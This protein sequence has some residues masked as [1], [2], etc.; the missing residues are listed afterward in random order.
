MV[1]EDAAY[2]E[3]VRCAFGEQYDILTAS[4]AEEALTSVWEHGEIAVIILSMTLPD[5]GAER[6]I[7]TLR[8]D[9]ALWRIPVLA[10]IPTGEAMEELPVIMETDDFLC[11]CHPMFDMRKRVDRLMD[12]VRSRKRERE[13]R[14]E[15]NRDFLTGLLNRRG[16]QM[17]VDSLSKADL[18][19][20]VYLFDLDNL[21]KTNDTCGHEI[22][23][24]VIQSF[25]SLLRR[26]TRMGD[27][28][29]RYGGDE[30]VAILQHLGDG[31]AALRK[32]Q[33]ICDAFRDSLGN[34]ALKTACTVGIALCG[35]NERPSMSLIERADRAMYQAKQNNKGGCCLWVDTD[36]EKK[37]E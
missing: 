25:A 2:W 1:D 37:P 9:M 5:R 14:D 32:G 21:D 10:S 29:C 33:R 19:Y 6:V 13:L 4:S 7:R 15:V 28:L 12:M 27:I 8:Q 30:F 20:A 35:E 31:E 24:Q 11:K 18:P 3:R 16:L 26:R 36:Q 17:A 22:G 34:D 23:D